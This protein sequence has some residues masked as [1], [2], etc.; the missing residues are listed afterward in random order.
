MNG[1]IYEITI[2]LQLPPPPREAGIDRVKAFTLAEVLI[3]LGIIGIVAAL[4]MPSLIAKYNK[5]ETLNILKKQ[6]SVINNALLLS[7]S[8]YGEFS[9]WGLGNMGEVGGDFEN[10]Q[11]NL[12][13]I[14][15]RILPYLKVSKDLGIGSGEG[16]YIT[17]LK[18]G[19][20]HKWH[21]NTHYLV[22]LSDGTRVLFFINNDKLNPDDEKNT[23][24]DLAITVDINGDKKPNIYGKDIFM[25]YITPDTKNLLMYGN[26]FSRTDMLKDCKNSGFYC[27]A[28][29]QYD[30]WEISDDYPW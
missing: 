3:T 2:D 27:G 8:E 24:K 21:S 14:V 22:Y 12:Q 5:A 4:T 18:N 28:L 30:G 29:I 6:T 17:Y 15:S 19:A 10:Y 11:K 16:K 20:I 1:G 9:E 25:Y 26:M 13:N 7:Q 23:Y